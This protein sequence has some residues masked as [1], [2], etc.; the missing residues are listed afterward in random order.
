LVQVI[1]HLNVGII[2]RQQP[3]IKDYSVMGR[4]SRAEFF[5]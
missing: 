3:A 1:L 2:K 4:M 5:K